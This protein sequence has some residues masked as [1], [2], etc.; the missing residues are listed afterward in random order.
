[1]ILEIFGAGFCLGYLFFHAMRGM[2]EKKTRKQAA[3]IKSTK[4]HKELWFER[5]AQD[6]GLVEVAPGVYAD[7]GSI[8]PDRTI[9]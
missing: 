6:M 3:P 8:K 4:T 7:G 9:H 2:H 1:M 5:L